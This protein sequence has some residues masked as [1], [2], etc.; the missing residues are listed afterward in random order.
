MSRC[1]RRPSC[2]TNIIGYVCSHAQAETC[3]AS[4]HQ[5]SRAKKVARVPPC[6]SPGASSL[7]YPHEEARTIFLAKAWRHSHQLKHRRGTVLLCLPRAR[8][9]L[10]LSRT[11]Q[12]ARLT[13]SWNAPAKPSRLT[14]WRGVKSFG[15]SVTYDRGPVVSSPNPTHDADLRRNR[16][17]TTPK[18]MHFSRDNVEVPTNAMNGRLYTSIN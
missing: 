18:A 6:L 5:P 15:N 12:P 4:S 8:T 14:C 2:L 3:W 13:G 16:D 11:R 9:A 7:E 10:E 17:G 1:C